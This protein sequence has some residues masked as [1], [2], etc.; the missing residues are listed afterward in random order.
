MIKKQKAYTR[1]KRKEQVLKQLT[2]WYETGYAEQATSYQLAKAL[3]IT[4][5]QRFRD[6]LNEMVDEG[7]LA[8]VERDQSGR[9]TTKFYSL[10]AGATLITSKLTRRVIVKHKGVVSGQLELAL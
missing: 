9:Y 6:L 2:I 3:E 10:V 1:K 7:L 8:V 5:Q 4:P